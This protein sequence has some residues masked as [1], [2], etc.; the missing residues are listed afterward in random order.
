MDS[1]EDLLLWVNA[2]R[3]A[4]ICRIIKG[5]LIIVS[6]NKSNNYSESYDNLEKAVSSASYLDRIQIHP[7]VYSENSIKITNGISIQG[8]HNVT[9][10]LKEGASIVFDT[11]TTCSFENIVVKSDSK[12]RSLVNV[13]QGSVLLDNCEFGLILI[14]IN[15]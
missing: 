11:R 13:V 14:M 4:S 1:F 9:I 3:K 5:K 6:K 7:G 8:V 2:L 15:F 10:E 12:E